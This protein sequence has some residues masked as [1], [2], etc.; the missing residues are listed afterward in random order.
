MESIFFDRHEQDNNDT[1]NNNHF[2]FK[3]RKCPPQNNN[4]DKFEADLLDMVHNIKFRNVNNKFQN[5]LNEDINK[6]K[7]S[8]KAF[9]PADKTSNICELDKM[10]HDKLLR[11]SITTTYKKASKDA[12]NIIDLQTK[13]IAQH[14][15]PH[16][17]NRKTKSLYY[18]K[19]L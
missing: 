13:S 8:T 5:K 10:Q 17:T 14:R 3:S 2:G 12:T 19:R 6:I 9:I 15:Q 18:S 16:R 11:G 7:K 1:A 4:L